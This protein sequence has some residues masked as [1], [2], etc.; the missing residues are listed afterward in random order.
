[1]KTR[2]EWFGLLSLHNWYTAQHAFDAFNLTWSTKNLTKEQRI[3]KLSELCPTMKIAVFEGIN[4]NDAAV[5]KLRTGL[6]VIAYD[7][8]WK[9][10]ES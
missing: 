7:Q 2:A 10:F 3:E 6:G 5:K 8:L 4:L 9:Q 1:M